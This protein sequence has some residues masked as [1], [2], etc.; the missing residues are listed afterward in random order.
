MAAYKF[1]WPLKLFQAC[2]AELSGAPDTREP[3]DENTSQ[4]K[5]LQ[6]K[7]Q[8]KSPTRIHPCRALDSYQIW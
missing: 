6:S 7:D 3:G 8:T 4:I 5:H 2:N 1:A